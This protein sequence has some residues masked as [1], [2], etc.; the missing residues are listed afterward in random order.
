[1]NKVGENAPGVSASSSSKF[2]KNEQ[3]EPYIHISDK[4]RVTLRRWKKMVLGKYHQLDPDWGSRWK[5]LNLKKLD[6]S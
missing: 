1:M 5:L 2:A 4:R 3:G 6:A